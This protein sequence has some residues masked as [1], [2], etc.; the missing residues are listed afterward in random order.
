MLSLDDEEPTR[1]ALF[2]L[3]LARLRS[4]K[5]VQ[6]LSRLRGERDEARLAY[7]S[8]EAHHT[9][10]EL[11]SSVWDHMTGGEVLTLRRDYLKALEENNQR[12]SHFIFWSRGRPIGVASFSL[13]NFQTPSIADLIT[14]ATPFT[15]SLTR[16]SKLGG[17]PLAGHLIT[18]G[19]SSD[20]GGVGFIF[21]EETSSMMIAE[22]LALAARTVER[23]ARRRG[24]KPSA[25]LFQDSPH[26]SALST[27]GY[28]RFESEPT[29][30]LSLSPRW[31]TFSDY[32]SD[33]TSKY[34]VKAKRADVKSSALSVAPLSAEQLRERRETLSALYHEVVNNAEISLYP[35]EVQRLDSLSEALQ[36]HVFTYGYWLNE[37]LIGY[38]VSLRHR[39]VLYAH[40]VGLDYRYNRHHSL[41]PRMLN[42]YVREGIAH[43]CRELHLGRTAGEIKSTLGAT[44]TPTSLLLR[45]CHPLVNRTLPLISRRT[46]L[47][48]FHLHHPFKAQRLE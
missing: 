17:Q 31:L 41:Y 37:R 33:L 3:H 35:P 8:L 48:E 26:L 46:A 40:L 16:W 10:D 47:K 28:T 1:C 32:L 20:S 11:P 23:S 36:E 2:P 22:A 45:H 18:C 14:R 5:R 29:M 13:M 12:S 30:T 34:R 27:H 15:R 25:I 7:L 9:V 6:A 42:D 44:P 43:R 19:G 39:G 21:V 38:R 24:I 4:P